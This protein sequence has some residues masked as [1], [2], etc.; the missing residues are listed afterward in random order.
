MKI[1]SWKCQ[2][3]RAVDI[4]NRDPKVLHKAAKPSSPPNSSGLTL[5]T[6]EE[7]SA[8]F[9]EPL[10]SLCSRK[11]AY[12]VMRKRFCPLIGDDSLTST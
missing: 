1:G 6:P 5:K 4:I 12:Y 8:N 10:L 7:I 9:Q 3:E 2:L 11:E